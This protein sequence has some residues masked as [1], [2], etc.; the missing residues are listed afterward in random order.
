MATLGE[1]FGKPYNWCDRNCDRCLL[2]DRC[3]LAL[4]EAQLRWRDEARGLDPDDPER[5]MA[6]VHDSLEEALTLLQRAAEEEG[7][8]LDAPYPAPVAD[9]AAERLKRV[10]MGVVTCLAGYQP[11]T[12]AQA[13]AVG[14]CKSLTMKL[15]T[16]IARVVGYAEVGW[17]EREVWE[18]DAVPNLLLV[19]HVKAKLRPALER[20][21][22]SA[23][24]TSSALDALDQLEPLLAPLLAGISADAR[25]TLAALEA[26][27][28]APSPFLVRLS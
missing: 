12:E 18:L 20:A 5:V 23:P 4:R 28:L 2:S 11:L 13:D 17:Q 9:L 15:V 21:Q 14:E 22:P 19:E 6:H 8:D 27:G 24:A 3:E 26:E 16:K 10:S 7:I 1:S 25:A